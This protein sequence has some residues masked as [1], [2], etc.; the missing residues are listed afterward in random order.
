MQ[1]AG[2]A[3][4]N[5]RQIGKTEAADGEVIEIAK[6]KDAILVTRDRDFADISLYPPGTH[7][8]I[9]LLRIT[10]Q[11]MDTVHKVL[12]EALRIIPLEYIPGNLLIVTSITYRLH[13]HKS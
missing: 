12:L 4:F 11:N 7:R 10:P 6:S 8:G 13:R 9:I 2:F 5:L 3:C 1:K